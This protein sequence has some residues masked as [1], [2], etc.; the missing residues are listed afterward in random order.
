MKKMLSLFFIL[1]MLVSLFACS[2]EIVK[3]E[4]IKKFVTEY[5]TIQ[6]T[7]KEPTNAPSGIEIGEQVKKYLSEDV[8]S[9]HNANRTFQIA[10]DIAKRTGKSIELDDILLEKEKEKENDNGT[11]N[12]SFT[13]KL[14]FYDASTSETVEKNGQLTI[15]NKD[16]FLITR[17]WENNENFVRDFLKR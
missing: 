7:I 17:D 1:L 3:D 12:Y 2:K 5:K 6:Y 11:I 4:D 15:S 13:L 9:K 8:F 14:K 10:P 16:G